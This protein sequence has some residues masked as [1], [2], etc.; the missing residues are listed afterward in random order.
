MFGETIKRITC[1][2]IENGVPELFM[3]NT[4]T[5]ITPQDIVNDIVL[6]D[7]KY[8]IL[9]SMSEQVEVTIGDNMKLVLPPIE[10]LEKLPNM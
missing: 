1:V 10:K 4:G 6:Y 8:K 7:V 2:R 5:I 3:L 9:F